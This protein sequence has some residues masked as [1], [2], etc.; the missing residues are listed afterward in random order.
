MSSGLSRLFPLALMLA[1]ALLTFWLERAVQEEQSHPSL[2]RHD[3]DFIV[4]RFTITNFGR[5]GRPESR[6]SARTMTHYPDDDSTTLV[7]PVL[8]QTKPGQPKMTL[9]ARDGA[10]SSDGEEVFLYEDVL[11]VRDAAEGRPESR[12]RT[13]FLHFVRA[14]SLARTDREVSLVE[15]GRILHARGMEY[16]NELGQLTLHARVRGTFEPKKNRP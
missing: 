16:E 14:R 6:V 4:E 10:L 2:R 12:M 1:L 7:A 3:P 5:D 15:E 11:L 8:V 9:T 13:P